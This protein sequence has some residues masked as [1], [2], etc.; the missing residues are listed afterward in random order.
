MKRRRTEPW[1]IAVGMRTAI[2]S[3]CAG[4]WLKTPKSEG[5]ATFW[6]NCRKDEQARTQAVLQGTAPAR[7]PEGSRGAG[8]GFIDMAKKAS[9]PIEFDFRKLNENFSFFSMKTVI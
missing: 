7:P 9:K 6:P 5:S 2:I 8:L 1:V 4:I 3:C